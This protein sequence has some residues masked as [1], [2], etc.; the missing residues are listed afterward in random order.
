MRVEH[1]EC[2]MVC[3]YYNLSIMFAYLAH[4]P[5]PGSIVLLSGSRQHSSS[6]RPSQISRV[7]P[8]GAS[9]GWQQCRRVQRTSVSCWV[10]TCSR[11]RAACS[12]AGTDVM[13]SELA[14][15]T[16]AEKGEGETQRGASTGGLIGRRGNSGGLSFSVLTRFLF[17]SSVMLTCQQR[18]R[19]P[20]QKKGLS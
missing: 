2:C 13:V 1:A 17:G 15:E 11:A 19:R 18:G 6:S 12:M 8:H 4:E 5:S 20:L 14:S 7:A 3:W 16:E 9:S 10:S